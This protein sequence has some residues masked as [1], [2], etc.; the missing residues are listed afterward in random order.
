MESQNP[1]TMSE[2]QDERLGLPS[3]SNW[4][5]YELCAGSWALEAEAR[6][7]NQLAH[8]T[9]PQ[10][11]RGTRIHAA[12][13]GVLDEDGQPIALN[14]DEQRTADFLQERSQGEVARIF[15]D[16]PWQQLSEKRL[17]L[18]V[19][20]KKV[21]SGRPDRV[22][23]NDKLAL[24]QDFKTGWREP[25]AAEQNAQLK[26]LAVIV[27]IALPSVEE[28]VV[29][30]ISGP[31]GVTEARYTLEALS[32]AYREVIATL[33]AINAEYAGFAPSSEACRYCPAINICEA[34]NKIA[35]TQYTMLPDGQ[36]AGAILDQC[37]V[38]ERRI[39]AIREHYAERM[40]N[41]PTYQVPGFAMMPGPQRRTVE[42][43][44]R[45][46]ARLD[47]FI[48]PAELEALANYSIPSVEKLVAKALKLKAKEAGVK[49]AEILGDLLTVR[50]GNLCL[51]RVSGKPKLVTLE[52]P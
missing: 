17:W 32:K 18:I 27:G 19:G 29:Q 4:R 1:K 13:A 41:D 52:L 14:E 22:V 37:E 25:D 36:Q 31:Y 23:Y 12:L 21:A 16:A 30:L 40:T 10:A 34:V 48:D 15:G 44:K 43:W 24:V 35:A 3:A 33:R 49:L 51:K 38:L 46:R 42:D 6:R 26:A 8:E 28:I 5:R 20:G 39:E 45:A 2:P 50:Q 11:E 9:S 47:E 7:L